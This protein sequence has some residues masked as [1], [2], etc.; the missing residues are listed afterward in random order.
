[1][2]TPKPTVD[3]ERI[4]ADYRAG[5]LSLRE[6]AI[7]HPGVSHVT[8]GNRA[9]KLGWT[10]SLKNRIEA[11]TAELVNRAALTPAINS[12]SGVSKATEDEV[13]AAN[14]QARTDVVLGNRGTIRRG[15]ALVDALL[16]ELEHQTV[17]PETYDQ[18]LAALLEEA[19]TP[20]EKA[21]IRQAFRKA[22]SVGSRV[23]AAAR[24]TEAMKNVIALQRQAWGLD[25]P[26]KPVDDLRELTDD[27]LL[28]R[29]TD[30]YANALAARG[31]D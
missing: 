2:T 16:A 21:E 9:K 13:V 20:A 23:S 24:L 31:Q 8:I 5:I 27:E 30:A 14:A 22:M 1:M 17:N 6:L 7:L 25:E 26:E 4:E 28:S 15:H 3:W 11:K 29:A 12:Q 10:R 19:A 18:M